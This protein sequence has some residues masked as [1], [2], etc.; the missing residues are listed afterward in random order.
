MPTPGEPRENAACWRGRQVAKPSMATRRC[1]F[2]RLRRR[3]WTANS[4]AKHSPIAWIAHLGKL[5][6]VSADSSLPRNRALGEGCS[7]FNRGL[8]VDYMEAAPANADP[9]TYKVGL[10]RDLP[11][12]AR[13]Y[14]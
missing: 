2:E 1:A 4:R 8:Q 6:L 11:R 7:R 10:H 3:F 14:A 13:I 9:Y 5:F 12:T